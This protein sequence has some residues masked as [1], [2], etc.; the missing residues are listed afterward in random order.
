M[1]TQIL[2]I[3]N[4]AAVPFRDSV[5]KGME[6]AFGDLIRSGILSIT[7]TGPAR[8][9]S[10]QLTFQA[11]YN[12]TSVNRDRNWYR[13][14][15]LGVTGTVNI[16]ALRRGNYCRDV[17]DRQ[18][19][20]AV[21]RELPGELGQSIANTAIHEAG[22]LFGLVNGGPDGSGHS[23]DPRNYMFINSLHNEY[24]PYLKDHRRTAKYRIRQGDS[25]SK[26]AD[27]I[28]FRSPIANCM[29]L[30]DFRGQDGRRNRDLLRSHDPNLIY[31]GEEIWIPD[32]QA[33]LAYMRA[34]EICP[35][36]FTG[37]QIATMKQFLAAGRTV[38]GTSP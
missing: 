35:K 7:F 16:E 28:G 9:S 5:R 1:P 17:G 32:I 24:A 2:Y 13:P 30:Y 36:V 31:P 38:F 37:P 18:T 23:S 22:H 19:C 34:L 15:I 6:D 3:S 29:A 14:M 33:R 12:W 20:E 26:I 11:S 25:L 8:N 21:V 10:Y 4:F 27:R